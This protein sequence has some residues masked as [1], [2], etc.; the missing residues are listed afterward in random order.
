MAVVHLGDFDI[1]GF[2]AKDAGGVA[3][4]P[5]EGVDSDGVVGSEDDG[6]GF[7]GFGDGGTLFVS[8]AGGADDEGGACGE[9]FFEEVVSEGGEGEVDDALGAREG[10]GEVFAFVVGG[11]EAG[12]GFG[13]DSGD[14]GLAHAS[15]A[16]GD[17]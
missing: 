15:G 13:F 3:G 8:V 1:E 11:V 4:E 17:C 7:G 14:D 12:A 6:D 5:E 10:C 2:V 9:G 16:S